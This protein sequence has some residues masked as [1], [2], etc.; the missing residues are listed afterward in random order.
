M[1][2]LDT[3]FRPSHGFDHG[4]RDSQAVFRALLWA[5]S[6]PGEILQCPI[7]C[8]APAPLT[9]AGAA[10][11]LTL[12]DGDTSVWLDS[13]LHDGAAVDYLRFH[14][15]ATLAASPEADFA[16]IAEPQAM[17][18]FTRYHTGS[19]EEPE[20]T[21]TLVLQVPAL[22]GGPAVA[23]RGPGIETTCSIGP[24]GLPDWFWA[25]WDENARLFPRGLDAVLTDGRALIALAR[26]TSRA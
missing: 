6:H 5:M 13:S 18:T 12:F 26:S 23:L 7:G 20:R 11:A 10:V 2:P 4:E 21:T 15:N 1:S 14:T 9:P 19:A 8:T 25:A 16:L 3:P 24:Q 17:P 22:T